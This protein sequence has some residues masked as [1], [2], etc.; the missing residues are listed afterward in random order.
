MPATRYLQLRSVVVDTNLQPI[1][2]LLRL[3]SL[4]RNVLALKRRKVVVVVAHKRNL[5]AI[6]KNDVAAYGATP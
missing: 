3:A 2:A 4:E 6:L 5:A 1:Q